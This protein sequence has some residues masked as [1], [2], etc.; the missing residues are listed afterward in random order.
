MTVS[1]LPVPTAPRPSSSLSRAARALAMVAIVGVCALLAWQGGPVGLAG[2]ALAA[3]AG[4]RLMPAFA[5]A[6]G[7][8]PEAPVDGRLG[9]EVM[10]SE[11][12]PVW[13]R[14][15]QLTGDVA[16]EG[17]GGILESFSSI[18]GALQSLVDQLQAQTIA[19]EP[20]QVD[21]TVRGQAA[22]LEP[23][24]A[25]SQRAFEQRDAAFVEVLAASPRR[26]HP[27]C[28]QQAKLARETRPP[29]P[30]GGLQRVDRGAAQPGNRGHDG[31]Q[32]V[33]NELRDLAARMAATGEAVA[34][35]AV[36]ARLRARWAAR[37]APRRD[38]RHQPDELRWSS[39]SRPRGAA[40]LLGALGT[41]AGRHTR[42][43]RGPATRCAASS[44]RP[45][46]TSSSATALSQMLS[47]S[48]TT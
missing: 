43:E 30:A 4:W 16:Q 7:E 19:A 29:H 5:A 36:R 26:L 28:K 37:V 42:G 41:F 9:A 40:G 18:S 12:V 46:C 32:A 24:L 17:V 3:V 22:A 35:V 44:T 1:A 20:G 2:L 13:S 33:A 11:V 45:S 34:R 25:A 8:L 10:V 15:M 39:T 47:S 6:G 27:N 38:P 23:L 31:S 21:A 14:Q 48:A